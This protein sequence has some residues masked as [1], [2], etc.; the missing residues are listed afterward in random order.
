MATAYLD[1]GQSLNFAMPINYLMSLK[2]NELNLVSL[3][4]KSKSKSFKKDDSLVQI[5]DVHYKYD[6]PY[7]SSNLLSLDFAIR[8]L[9]NYPIK[10]IQIFI[11]YKNY[12]GEIVSY[13]AEKF[14]KPILPQLALQFSH[15]HGV[16]YFRQDLSGKYSNGKVEIRILDYEVDRISGTSPADLLFK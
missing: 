2:Q 1:Y 12:K 3:P 10:N 7:Y 9:S 14:K 16:D 6:C 11:V 13:S 15:K 4:K 8:N 5:F